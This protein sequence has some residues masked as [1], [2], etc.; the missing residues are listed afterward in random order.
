MDSD[1]NTPENAAR[2]ETGDLNEEPFGE[3]V[4]LEINGELDLHTFSP[5]DIGDLIPTWF[6]ECRKVGLLDVRVIHGKG[7]GALRKG[8]HALLDRLPQVINY[9]L[10]DQASGSWGATKV[11][12]KPWEDA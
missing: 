2:N 10:G 3:P 5:R 11:R 9:K 7:T 4:P 12:L 1:E 6:D 8:V